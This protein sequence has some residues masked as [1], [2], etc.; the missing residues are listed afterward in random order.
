MEAFLTFLKVAVSLA[1]VL[2]LAYWFM[3]YLLP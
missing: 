2:F 1:L 3:R